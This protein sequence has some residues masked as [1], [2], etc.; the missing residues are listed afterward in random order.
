MIRIPS[1][2]SFKAS[3][4]AR[5]GSLLNTLGDGRVVVAIGDLYHIWSLVTRKCLLT[6]IHNRFLLSGSTF[7]FW[8][9]KV[10]MKLLIWL[11]LLLCNNSACNWSTFSCYCLEESILA[12]FWLSYLFSSFAFSSS[13]LSWD[14]S[15]TDPFSIFPHPIL[16][17]V[18]SA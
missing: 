5:L 13:N 17:V 1:L 9:C 3:M 6:T 2:A 16:F 15:A 4:V 7:D 10:L 18:V 11:S 8:S 12:S 14:F